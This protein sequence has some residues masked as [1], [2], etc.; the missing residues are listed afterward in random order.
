MGCHCLLADH[1]A[2]RLQ[3]LALNSD[4]TSA[5][6][7][8]TKWFSAFSNESESPSFSAPYVHS[9]SNIICINFLACIPLDPFSVHSFRWDMCACKNMYNFSFFKMNLI[10]LNI[11]FCHCLFSL[12]NTPKRCFPIHIGLF[13]SFY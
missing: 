2:N 6:I 13:H 9:L 11:L 10:I 7:F 5:S 4:L 8:L 3:T 1:I 12:D